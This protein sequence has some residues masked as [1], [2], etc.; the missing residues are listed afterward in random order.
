MKEILETNTWTD[1]MKNT[2]HADQKRVPNKMFLFL[3]NFAC[4]VFTEWNPSLPMFRQSSPAFRVEPPPHPHPVHR[5]TKGGLVRL[6]IEWVICQEKN[7]YQR[8]TCIC[9]LHSPIGNT[10][11]RTGCTLYRSGRCTFRRAY[12]R[13]CVQWWLS[14]SS[15][16][17]QIQVPWWGSYSVKGLEVKINYLKNVNLYI[18]LH[19]KPLTLILPSGKLFADFN[20]KPWLRLPSSF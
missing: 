15:W 1:N 8:L 3:P 9:R 12:C 20:F 10:G 11:S 6:R 2:W 14:A 18:N 19:N 5:Y 4:F 17:W 16:N 13:C 7:I